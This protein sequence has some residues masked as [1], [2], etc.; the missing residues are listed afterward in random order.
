M[1]V[2]ICECS[3]PTLTFCRAPGYSI[4]YNNRRPSSYIQLFDLIQF[5]ADC[6]CQKW[7][8]SFKTCASKKKLCYETLSH[9]TIIV[10]HFVGR[11]DQIQIPRNS[12][13]LCKPPLLKFDTFTLPWNMYNN[14]F[15]LRPDKEFMPSLYL[16][17]FIFIYRCWNTNPTEGYFWITRGQITLSIVVSCIIIHVVFLYKQVIMIPYLETCAQ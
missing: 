16:V 1:P 11:G 3:L 5:D 15:S 10:C 2:V 8:A 7:K 6:F 13:I 9:E 14:N 12:W 17:S 4:Y